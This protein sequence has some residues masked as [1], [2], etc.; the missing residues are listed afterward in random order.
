VLAATARHRAMLRR[1]RREPPI[2]WED[3]NSIIRKLMEM[4][5]KLNRVLELLEAEDGEEENR[6]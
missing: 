6:S 2:T 4:D 5:V 1:R 3:V